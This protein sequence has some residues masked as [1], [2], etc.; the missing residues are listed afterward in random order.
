MAIKVAFDVSEAKVR[1][2]EQCKNQFWSFAHGLCLFLSYKESVCAA[3]STILVY[4]YILSGVEKGEA[5]ALVFG[6]GLPLRYPPPPIPCCPKCSSKGNSTMSVDSRSLKITSLVL[7]AIQNFAYGLSLTKSRQPNAD[8]NVFF[9]PT[10]VVTTEL[11]KIVIALCGLTWQLRSSKTQIGS[12]YTPLSSEDKED[13]STTEEKE[14]AESSIQTM[15]TPPARSSLSVMD[16]KTAVFNGNNL[17]VLFPA[18]LF[19]CQNNLQI[20]SA[21][22]LDATEFQ[23]LAQLKLVTAA[24]CSVLMLKKKLNYQ[25]WSC[26]L[27]L[28]VGICLVQQGSSSSSSTSSAHAHTFLIG[29]AAMLGACSFSGV[30]SISMEY[31][32]KNEL[33][34]WISNLILAVY[35]IIPASIPI[36]ADTIQRGSFDPYRYFTASVWLSIGLNAIG[37][38]LVSMVMKYADNILKGFAVSAALIATLFVNSFLTHASF[39]W[40]KLLGALIVVGSMAGYGQVKIVPSSPRPQVDS[41]KMTSKDADAASLS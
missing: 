24:I 4:N 9:G 20:M 15:P 2:I 41:S 22:Y 38:V 7:L 16:L 36:F 33:G 23:V 14:W 25:H 27:F 37:G 8:G 21:S 1:F 39:S 6:L 5:R 11:L 34:F 13:L 17:R 35:S 26:I 32:L 29:F 10:A 12:S 3:S 40:A 28:F 19:V 31:L 30:A 18:I